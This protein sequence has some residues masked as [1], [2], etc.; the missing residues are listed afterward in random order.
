MPLGAG[1]FW[2]VAMVGMSNLQKMLL[3]GL[4]GDFLALQKLVPVH[5]RSGLAAREG[6]ELR[7]APCGLAAL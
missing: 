1:S 6:M 3:S 7:G 4:R 5:K 2:L